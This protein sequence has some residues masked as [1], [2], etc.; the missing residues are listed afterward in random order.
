MKQILLSVIVAFMAAAIVSCAKAEAD[1]FNVIEQQALEAWISKNAPDAKPLG[2]SGIYYEVIGEKNQ[3]TSKVDVK[4]RWVEFNYVMRNLNGDIVYSRNEKTARQLGTYNV[5]THYVPDMM[6][7]ATKAEN[8]GIPAGIYE[9]I[10]SI[11]PGEMWK[12]Y[13]PSKLA[14][15]SSGYKITT[16][17]GGQQAL[18]G[19]VSMIL[20]SLQITDIIENPEKKAQEDIIRLATSPKPEGWAMLKNDTVKK[21][22]YLEIFRRLN[23]NDTVIMNQSANIYYK[24]RFLDGKLFNTNVDSVF[25]SHF[26]TIRS[27]DKTSPIRV[28][29]M[30]KAPNNAEHVPAKVFYAILP[31]LCYGDVGQ[32]VVPAVYA[33]GKNYMHPDKSEKNWEFSAAFPYDGYEYSDYQSID[34]DYY[35]GE[36]TF[37][38]P[39]NF[40]SEVPTAEIK[41]YTPIILEFTVKRDQQ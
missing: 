32:V 13:I 23:E 10:T 1:D 9:A 11:P 12:V 7:I 17:Y 39:Y 28:T 29:R 3:N 38:M 8:S 40:T 14:F 35:F 30:E 25:M 41:P 31:K 33:Y 36:N 21:G 16:G 19:N 18:E 2:D 15:S 4:G 26:G 22:V 6:Y 5:Y 37:Y 20:D 27:N 34:T 24:A